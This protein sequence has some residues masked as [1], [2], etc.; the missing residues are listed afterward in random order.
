MPTRRGGS[1]P[2]SRTSVKRDVVV[3][4]KVIEKGEWAREMQ[5]EVPAGRI[6]KELDR[7][8]RHYQKRVDVP[9]FRKG[10]APLRIIKVRYGES[11]RG[12]VINDLLP[13]LLEEATRET[14]LVPVGPPT[15]AKLTYEPGREL[16]FT[17]I[18]EIWPEIEIA[19]WENLKV[20]AIVHEV[21]DEEIDEQMEDI[22][23]RQATEQ[24]VQRE[25]RRGDVLIA[26][27]QRLDDTGLPIIG[28]KFEERYFI[29]GGGGTNN[30][31][32]EE[33]LIGVSAGEERKVRFVYRDGSPGEEMAGREEFFSVKVRE[34]RERA[35]P[36]LDDEFARDVGEHFRSLED[37]REHLSTQLA[38]RWE[39]MGRHHLRNSLID[40]LI[41]A[42]PF[43][44]PESMV[45][46]YLRNI[47]K[48]RAHDRDHGHQYDAEND[49]IH[50]E[51]EWT[52]AVRSLKSYLVI[53]AVRKK[54]AIK[55]SDEELDQYLQK[56]AVEM[57]VK[58][59]DVKRS[60]GVESLRRELVENKVF[61]FLL[62]CADVEEKSV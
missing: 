62:E 22:R 24:S 32:F 12:N 47:H 7:A 37:L 53:E 14:G 54:A 19:D 27:L 30:P 8:Y 1:N 42:N 60:D 34:I 45:K 50:S 43:D 28:D 40:E 25:L 21:T 9:G 31:E 48:E 51:E 36:A 29:I 35:L 33:A 18:L 52:S 41:K 16:Q 44:L 49:H 4:T 39:V 2:P 11:I 5:V 46:N 17:A 59:E 6:E 56:R 23:N 15:I 57:G 26:D 38:Q 20:T 58:I 10:K 55:V 13:T 3:K 61:D